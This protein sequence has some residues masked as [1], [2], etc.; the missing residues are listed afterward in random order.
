MPLPQQAVQIMVN[1]VTILNNR[2][3]VTGEVLRRGYTIVPIPQQ[4]IDEDIVSP[5]HPTDEPVSSIELYSPISH[6]HDINMPLPQQAVQIMLN[7]VTILNNRHL[8]T[9]EVLRLG[10]RIVPYHSKSLIK[11]LSVHFTLQTNL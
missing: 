8:V 3:L 7:Q 4:V 5:P 2:H 11:T 9:G 1:Q 10:Y 6:N